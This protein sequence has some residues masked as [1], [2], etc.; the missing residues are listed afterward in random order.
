M[1]ILG[2]MVAFEMEL[3]Y[4]ILGD[5]TYLEQRERK[6]GFVQSWLAD[7]EEIKEKKSYKR[8]SQQV[9]YPGQCALILTQEQSWLWMIIYIYIYIYIFVV[10]TS[11]ETYDCVQA[12]R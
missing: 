11:I 1:L 5:C 12:H 7:G 4:F 8:S 6:N 10:L 3:T 2:E 9:I